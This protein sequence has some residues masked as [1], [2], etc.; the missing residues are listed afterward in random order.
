MSAYKHKDSPFYHFDFQLKGARFHGSTGC[1]S[2]R[3]AEAFER[4]E[5]ERAKQQ[6]RSSSS[7][8]TKLD[9]VAGRYWNEVGQ[10][11]AGAD[12]TWRVQIFEFAGA[13][14]MRLNECLLKWAEVNWD[15]RRIEKQGKGDKRVSVPITDTVREILWPLRG[16]H[17]EMVFTYIA[18]RT[19]KAQKLIKGE[20]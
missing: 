14:G 16:H 13:S 17:P 19:R 6:V 7:I 18:K 4:T 11:H 2:K 8:S 3:E 1:T 5:R 12:T 20:R 10:H 15:A 9:D